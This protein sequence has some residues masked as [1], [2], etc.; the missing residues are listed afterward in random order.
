MQLKFKDSAMKRLKLLSALT[1]TAASCSALAV[2]NHSY[3]IY[4]VRHADKIITDK[5]NRNPTLTKCGQQRAQQLAVMLEHIPL[6]R[7][8]STDFKRT[9]LTAKPVAKAKSLAITSYDP[10]NLTAISNTLINAKQNALVVG[11]NSTTNV[12]AGNLIN[13]TLAAIDHDEYDRVYQ[14]TITKSGSRLQLLN[15]GFICIAQ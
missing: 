11:H 6:E 13:E 9:Q 3:S 2:T 4:L 1:I 14:V 12:I 10:R 8:Y 5:T 15:Q 7:I